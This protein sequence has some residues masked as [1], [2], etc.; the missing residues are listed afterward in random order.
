MLGLALAEEEL[1][2]EDA[3][4]EQAETG[5]RAQGGEITCSRITCS[6]IT[7]S[8]QNAQ[9]DRLQHLVDGSFGAVAGLLADGMP[10]TSWLAPA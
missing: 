7:C 4:V 3:D 9:A 10:A 8:R 5:R 2:G 6:R 1:A